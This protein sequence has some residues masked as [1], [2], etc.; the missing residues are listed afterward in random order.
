MS[1]TELI[2]RTILLVGVDASYSN[3]LQQADIHNYRV[4]S[5]PTSAA[6]VTYIREQRFPDVVVLGDDLPDATLIEAC[7]HL[8]D[9]AG[10]VDLPLIVMTRNAEDDHLN[11]LFAHGANDC[12]L[13]PTPGPILWARINQQIERYTLKAALIHNEE[14]YR[15][16]A[17]LASEYAYEVAVEPD[18]TMHAL[19]ITDSFTTI[20]GYAFK[21]L[22]TDFWRTLLHSEDTDITDMRNRQLL[23]G[24]ANTAEF[25]IMPRVGGAIWV[26]DHARPIWDEDAGRVVRIYGVGRDITEIRRTREAYKN[27]QD[28]IEGALA[29]GEIGIW[30]WDVSSDDT[31]F[32]PGWVRMLGYEPDDIEQKFSAWESRIHP[33][34]RS[35]IQNALNAHFNHEQPYVVEHRLRTKDGTWRWIQAR[36]RV[37]KRDSR[38]QPL[39]MAGI[40]RDID[41]TR[42]MQEAL[43]L[44]EQRHRIIS[45]T[46]SDYAYSYIVQPDG[47]LKKDWSTQAFH[48]ITGYTFDEVDVDGWARMI[49]PDDNAVTGARYQKLM[50]GEMD[51]SEFRIIT[52]TGEVRWL[53]D[54]GHPVIDPETG[55][56]VHIYGAAQDI[57][58]AK[59]AET[60]LR[61]QAIE[62]QARNEEL[63]AFAYTVA[64]DLKNPISSM[65]GFASLMQNYLG[66][67]DEQVIQE[68]L[69]LIMESGYKLKEIINALLMLAGVSKMKEADIGPLDMDD[70]VDG[71]R[72]RLTT[73]INEQNAQIITLDTWPIARGYAPWVEEI[74]ANYM[75]N[76]IKY[77]GEPPQIQLGAEQLNDEMIR[78]WIRD[79]G[80]GLDAEQ[81]AR[82][83]TPFERLNRDQIEGHGLGLSVVQRIVERLGGEVS[84]ESTPGEG[85]TFSFTLPVA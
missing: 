33:D 63:D 57:T 5:V 14:R 7:E 66:R 34:D 78:F 55:Q 17:E 21:D 29:A 49:H 75:S 85:S 77:G 35:I 40:H 80:I 3:Q 46:I 36:G 39:R 48:D 82:I 23:R 79:N 71:A 67:M 53:R 51:I 73:L 2:K 28:I 6:A 12:V 37:I 52:K 27:S 72:S 76:A 9:I 13:L 16:F 81:Q 26:R 56:V 4:E 22:T 18:S 42:R 38:G 58:D 44:S 47:S 11:G 10:N 74:W 43:E 70:I 20:T 69:Q 59:S 68:Y 54:H 60:M 30:D 64:H 31:Y 15:S 45:E 62:L 32:S 83:F 1:N 19:W 25:R 65:M 41:E 50:R 8:K 24:E 84:V 61:E